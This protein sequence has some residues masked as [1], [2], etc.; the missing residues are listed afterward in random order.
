MLLVVSFSYDDIFKET[1]NEICLTSMALTSRMFTVSWSLEYSYIFNLFIVF[2]VRK[3]NSCSIIRIL[4]PICPWSSTS[5]KSSVYSSRKR[6]LKCS[7][8]QYVYYCNRDCQRESWTD[9]KQEC[10]NL[11]RVSPRIV[12]DAAR[13]LARIIFKLQVHFVRSLTPWFLE[14]FIIVQLIK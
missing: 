5:C 6:L 10:N 1:D 2:T 3:H 9:H 14:S 8:C 4:F 11:R 12:P 7:G 13:L